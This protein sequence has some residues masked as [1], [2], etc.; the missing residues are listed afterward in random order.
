MYERQSC[1]RLTLTAEKKDEPRPTYWEYEL[2]S[3][4]WLDKRRAA[5][6]ANILYH[7][8]CVQLYIIGINKFFT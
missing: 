2:D 4:P 3:L 5:L 7:Q 6:D 1:G 8:I